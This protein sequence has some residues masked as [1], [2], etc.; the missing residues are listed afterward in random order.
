M[1]CQTNE[2]LDPN[3][4]PSGARKWRGLAVTTPNVDVSM[5]R[6]RIEETWA[7]RF[8]HVVRYSF[9]WKEDHSVWMSVDMTPPT[10]YFTPASAALLRDW[11][12][13]Y[14]AGY[15]ERPHGTVQLVCG[16]WCGSPFGELE[17]T[18]Q[19]GTRSPP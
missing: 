2:P 19:E 4:R 9:F 3:P 13:Y 1:A 11:L 16:Q 5:V 18:H 7:E 10:F 6:A 12:D 17:V 14:E 8:A 15:C